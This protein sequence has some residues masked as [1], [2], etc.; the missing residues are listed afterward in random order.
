MASYDLSISI[1]GT[2]RASGVFNNLAWSFSRIGQIFGGIVASRIFYAIADGIS[3]VFENCINATAQFQ[4]MRATLEGLVARELVGLS[5]GLKNVS[6]VF[7]EARERAAA[8]MDELS[9]M[10]IL[11]PYTVE[12]TMNVFRMNMAFGFSVDQSKK[13][14]DALLNY[15][16]AIGASNDMLDRMAYNL[17]QIR[18]QGKVTALDIRQ[19][20]LAGFDLNSVLVYVG[21]QMGINI[22]TH[23]DFNRAIA[24]GKI[25][26]ED[27]TKYF[28]KYADENFAGAAERLAKTLI[29]LKSTFHDVWVLS[30]PKL[31]LPAIDEITARIAKLLDFIVLLRDS[32]A[33]DQ[34]GERWR[35]AV[36]KW[37]APIDKAISFLEKYARLIVAMGKQGIN[38]HQWNELKIAV[39][40][41]LGGMDILHNVVLRLFGPEG[42]KTLD[43]YIAAWGRLQPAVKWVQKTFNDL[44]YWFLILM[45]AFKDFWTIYGPSIS[46]SFK[47]IGDALAGLGKDSVT[48]GVSLIGKIV[49]AFYLFLTGEGGAAIAR[50]FDSLARFIAEKLV[51]VIKTLATW[52][53]TNIPIAY[54]AV[55]DFW[56]LHLHPALY[57]FWQFVT[58][59]L[60]PAIIKIYEW[61]KIHIPLAFAKVQEVWETKLQPALEKLRKFIVEDV[62]PAFG[63]LRD[64]IRDKLIPWFETKIPLAFQAVKDAYNDH[65]KPAF[66]KIH[67]LIDEKLVPA[68]KKL[69][70]WCKVHIPEAW[71]TLKAK[72]EQDL[73]PAL[74]KIKL[75]LIGEDG[76]SGVVGAVKS[77]FTVFEPGPSTFGKSALTAG[78]LAGALKAVEAAAPGVGRMVG[79]LISVLGP[80]FLAIIFA[81]SAALGTAAKAGTP[82]TLTAALS[83][84]TKA[85]LGAAT[86]VWPL[87]VVLAGLAVVVGELTLG[88]GALALAWIT[89]FGG[90]RDF[91]IAAVKTLE[92]PLSRISDGLG[93]MLG[94]AKDLGETALPKLK[95][96]W[97]DLTTAGWL[98]WTPL[99]KIVDTLGKMYTAHWDNVTMIYQHFQPAL[100]TIKDFITNDYLPMLRDI[101]TLYGNVATLLKTGFKVAHDLAAIYLGKVADLFDRILKALTGE[102][103]I[104][105]LLD[106]IHS[107]ILDKLSGTLKN[108]AELILPPVATV[109]ERIRDAISKINDLILAAIK[110]LEDFANRLPEMFRPGSPPPLEKAFRGIASAIKAAR[111][112][113]VGFGTSS[114]GAL[115]GP[116]MPSS[117][118]VNVQI[119]KMSTELDVE[120]TFQQIATRLRYEM[121]ISK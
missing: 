105:A 34:I 3:T 5:D 38:I 73:K 71:T 10:A 86:S 102:E 22:K 103:G 4:L 90:F 27:F 41:L 20:A 121:M 8:L 77:L 19:L 97:D 113:Y 43:K 94:F 50:W 11:S 13:L 76:Q 57:D 80:P 54:K 31:I 23:L 7:P 17:A 107:L 42:V 110:A 95:T 112:A 55:S 106:K 45:K 2:D 67:I 99:L 104:H 89:N 51:P 18:R 1:I 114:F 15:A 36:A 60:V 26:W 44:K 14:T 46:N 21:K 118:V 87:L 119:A 29:G 9:K 68:L 108:L 58:T 24:A 79:M 40:E 61:L 69:Y 48:G 65:I 32:K 100:Q 84:A 53:G 78:L 75:I 92:E 66:N 116:R 63:R 37:L 88:I 115:G 111:D 33:M 39:K 64:F 85:I 30:M 59:K 25:T 74:E 117:L 56:Q 91:T 109:F 120:K 93:A 52:V 47:V 70:N 49:T 16:A 35:A 6:D 12:L 83:G 96:S 82:I 62:I 98:L 28:Q 72:W 101:L 81:A